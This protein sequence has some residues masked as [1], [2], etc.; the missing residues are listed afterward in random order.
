MG[1]LGPCPNANTSFCLSKNQ[2]GAW[3]LGHLETPVQLVR[4]GCYPIFE[5]E[6]LGLAAHSQSTHLQLGHF[7]SPQSSVT[8]PTHNTAVLFSWPASF[9][10]SDHLGQGQR[11]PVSANHK[12]PFQQN[13]IECGVVCPETCTGRRPDSSALCTEH[14]CPC[15]KCQHP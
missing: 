1:S 4:N 13:L 2:I 15:G 11:W 8:V 9:I 7:Q 10:F 5:D 12:E 3:C 14:F 6:T